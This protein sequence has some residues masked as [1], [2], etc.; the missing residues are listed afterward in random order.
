MSSGLTAPNNNPGGGM[1]GNKTAK[2]IGL[3]EQLQSE[4]Q[5]LDLQVFQDQMADVYYQ[6]DSLYEQFGSDQEE[7]LITG[8]KPIKISRAEIQGKFN[9]VPN[10]KLDNSNPQLRMNKAFNLMRVFLN[11]PMINQREL[12]EHFLIESDVRLA[13]LLLK[14]PEQLAQES[15]QQ[16]QQQQAAKSESIQTQLG[17]KTAADNLEVRKAAMMVPI[18]GK[19]YA[20]D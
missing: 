14:T 19:K 12:K 8:E 18:E 17:L 6:I 10:G 4:V 2:E 13:K 1:Q 3:V 5:A 16:M 20:A 9:I 7:I 11:D 15:Q